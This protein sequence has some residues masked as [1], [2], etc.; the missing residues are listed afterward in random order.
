MT[1]SDD[2][3]H[4][5][6]RMNRVTAPLRAA[7][8][9]LALTALLAA[10]AA[11]APNAVRES[12]DERTGT[13]VTSLARP[14]EL[15]AVEARGTNAD[16]FAFVAPFE[17]NRAGV[18]AIYLWAAVPN[19]TGAWQSLRLTLDD[20]LPLPLGEPLADPK[21]IALDAFPYA[22]PTPWALVRAYPIS[23]ESL[24]LIAQARRIDLDARY[25]QSADARFRGEITPP[26]LLAE[27]VSS[28]G[29]R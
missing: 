28:L 20:S 23:E 2:L 9:A 18:R 5:T 8:G 25:A 24:K 19:E 6:G 7:R 1:S 14:L 10:C 27:F 17:T 15:V 22:S 13:T 11:G 3:H 16:P 29:L 26:E 12:L 21:L 4:Y